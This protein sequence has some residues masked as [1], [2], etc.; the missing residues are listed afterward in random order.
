MSF[1]YRCRV[2]IVS[3]SVLSAVFKYC[4]IRGTSP[5]KSWP[6]LSVP[7]LMMVSMLIKVTSSHM[8]PQVGPIKCKNEWTNVKFRACHDK[9]ARFIII[10]FIMQVRNCFPYLFFIH[11]SLFSSDACC[12]PIRSIV[13]VKNHSVNKSILLTSIFGSI[14]CVLTNQNSRIVTYDRSACYEWK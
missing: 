7:P 3:T 8:S 4:L 13:C 2:H 14:A 1:R 6:S 12:Y 9:I 10:N 5:G 11:E